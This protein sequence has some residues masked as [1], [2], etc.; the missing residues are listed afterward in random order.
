MVELFQNMGEKYRTAGFSR[1]TTPVATRVTGIA[2][3]YAIQN[4][5]FKE[6]SPTIRSR[7]SA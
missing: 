7:L 1:R 6:A 5:E 2:N 4:T 3:E